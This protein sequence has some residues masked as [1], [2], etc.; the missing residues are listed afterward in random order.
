MFV[1][2]LQGQQ[3]D[4]SG[5][6]NRDS[7]IDGYMEDEEDPET[8]QMGGAQAFSDLRDYAAPVA[9]RIVVS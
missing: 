7:L 6:P 4:S 5:S 9:R 8:Q 3:T 2:D 1:F